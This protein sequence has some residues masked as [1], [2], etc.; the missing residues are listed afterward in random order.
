MEKMDN[1]NSEIKCTSTTQTLYTIVVW[2][3]SATA[4]STPKTEKI[5][6]MM[7]PK[8]H[9]KV[10]RPFLWLCC[11]HPI[12]FLQ[13]QELLIARMEMIL[14]DFIVELRGS[15]WENGIIDLIMHFAKSKC[16]RHTLFATNEMVK[17]FM[18][19]MPWTERMSYSVRCRCA[20]ECR[21]DSQ[22]G[23]ENA[24]KCVFN[25]RRWRPHFFIRFNFV[26]LSV[27]LINWLCIVVVSVWMQYMYCAEKY[28][29]ASRFRTI[30]NKLEHNYYYVLRTTNVPVSE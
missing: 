19:R 11:L 3:D 1:N 20:R 18:R 9:P 4:M 21:E 16:S 6:I 30:F 14:D 22:N 27:L 28:R 26:W 15:V 7:M 8:A 10:K 23:N 12:L 5:S 2:N 25:G 24:M 13:F 29:L 17:L